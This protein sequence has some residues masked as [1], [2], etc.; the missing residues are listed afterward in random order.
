MHLIAFSCSQNCV[1]T[2]Y[3]ALSGAMGHIL[4]WWAQVYRW[5]LGSILYNVPKRWHRHLYAYMYIDCWLIYK[6]KS[7]LNGHSK[8]KTN[9]RLMQVKSIA[10]CSKGSILQYFRPSLSYHYWAL[11]FV[12][13]EW[14]LKSVLT[15]YMYFLCVTV[16]LAERWILFIKVRFFHNLK[17]WVHR[18]HCLGKWWAIFWNHGTMTRAHHKSEGLYQGFR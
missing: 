4:K 5:H 6:V 15:T 11:C 12:F 16:W 18:A 14:L 9:Y 17:G 1:N 13:F 10:E 3:A 2:Q 8:K 7:V